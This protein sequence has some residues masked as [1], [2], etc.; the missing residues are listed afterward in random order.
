MEHEPHVL[1][2]ITTNLQN[3]LR[4][5]LP[6]SQTTPS[7]GDGIAQDGEAS[8]HGD[9]GVKPG[10]LALEVLRHKAVAVTASRR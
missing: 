3:G 4:P 8:W 7:H 9:A 2:F 6:V 10:N 5:A 1:A